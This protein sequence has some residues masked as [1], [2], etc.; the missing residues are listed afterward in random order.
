VTAL[1]R[2]WFLRGHLVEGE[3]WLRGVLEQPGGQPRLRM[4][5]LA[6]VPETAHQPA[7]TARF[8]GMV[9]PERIHHIAAQRAAG[10]DPVA[11]IAARTIAW[12]RP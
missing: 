11:S 5:A 2:F 9:G 6:G 8:S 12:P 4:G 1:W 7:G 3:Q 10:V